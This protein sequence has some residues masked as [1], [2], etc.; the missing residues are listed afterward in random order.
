AGELAWTLTYGGAIAV[1][2]ALSF[3]RLIFIADAILAGA[4]LLLTITPPPDREKN[5]LL[6]RIQPTVEFANRQLSD[7]AAFWIVMAL[8]LSWKPKISYQIPALLALV[9]IGPP[10]V[11]WIARLASPGASKA[12]GIL[13]SVRR[14]IIY[15]ATLLGLFVLVL[16]PLDDQFVNVLP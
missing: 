10:L 2:L 6:W 14:P 9:L 3:W 13:Q 15:A 8:V 1:S 4:W 5:R 16:R 12:N 7:I 11:D